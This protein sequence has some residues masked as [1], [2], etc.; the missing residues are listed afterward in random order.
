M[1]GI[2]FPVNHLT[3][4]GH[5]LWTGVDTKNKTKTA[6]GAA[7]FGTLRTVRQKRSYEASSKPP[8]ELRYYKPTG[9]SNFWFCGFR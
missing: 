5:H 8:E 1:G 6:K 9:Q 3:T 7:M 2:V 4:V